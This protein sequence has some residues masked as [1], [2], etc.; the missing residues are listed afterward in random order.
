MW[1]NE[2]KFVSEKSNNSD[3]VI[4]L[5]I[6]GN[7]KQVS[8]ELLTTVKD[9]LLDKTFSGKHNL[10][11]VNDHYF[12]DRDPKI[13]DMVLNYLRYDTNYMPKNVDSETKRLFEMEIEHWGIDA[14]E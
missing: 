3:Q 12:L 10:K 11:T 6:G 4:K 8:K 1:E 9:S 2:K 13:F 14:T 7:L 5:N